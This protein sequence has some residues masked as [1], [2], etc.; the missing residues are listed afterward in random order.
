MHT[1]RRTA[2]STNFPVPLK[3][4]KYP[5]PWEN[6]ACVTCMHDTE[7]QNP[8]EFCGHNGCC[9]VGRCHLQVDCERQ[10][11]ASNYIPIP[12][13]DSF[14]Y[15]LNPFQPYNNIEQAEKRCTENPDCVAYNSYGYLK[16]KV[17]APAFWETQP[18]IAK[19]LPWVLYLKKTK[20]ENNTSSTSIAT[21]Y[22]VKQF[23]DLNH[24][25]MDTTAGI[26]RNC[27]QCK[28][29]IDCPQSAHC[30]SGCCVSNPCY[31]A[32]AVGGGW[33]DNE[34]SRT[35]Q[36]NCPA[37]KP[38]CCQNDPMD[39]GSQAGGIF[40][41]TCS[42]IPCEYIG[43]KLACGYLCNS[44]DDKHD[45]VMCKA[46][47]TC[48]NAGSGGPIC[49]GSLSGCS[50]ASSGI[51]AT[52]AT[53]T[54]D[55]PQKSELAPTAAKLINACNTPPAIFCQSKDAEYSSR[56]CDLNQSCCN[57]H[58]GPPTCCSEGFECVADARRQM[59]KCVVK[60][61]QRGWN[62]FN[63]TCSVATEIG[64]FSTR[65]LCMQHCRSPI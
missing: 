10:A 65:K 40:P 33:D 57:T 36:C 48:C 37:S 45:S 5:M 16:Y 9:Q 13:Y 27:L 20:L 28:E 11:N 61:D 8:D 32:T 1:G 62:C 44:M 56:M 64:A 43:K 63:G 22:G 47:E 17:V 4:G 53:N 6:S 26:C 50:G 21:P 60:Q 38:H 15:D 14:G 24:T 34:F 18:P 3:L 55:D 12:N 58:L 59:N 2:S 31:T 54:L 29:T 25:V 41:V 7:C 39:I 23:C 42:D 19:L 35:Q 49:C 46:D 51:N 52:T 30:N